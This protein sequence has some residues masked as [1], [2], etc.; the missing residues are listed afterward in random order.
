[1]D[2]TI[3]IV[4]LEKALHRILFNDPFVNSTIRS[5]RS[6]YKNGNLSIRVM[7]KLLIQNGYT[8]S[9]NSLWEK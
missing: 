7:E 5:Y 4:S 1:M 3:E 6:R 9:Q 8:K 2:K